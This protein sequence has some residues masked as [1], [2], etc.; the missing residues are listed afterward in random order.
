MAKGKMEYKPIWLLRLLEKE[1]T[2]TRWD[3]SCFIDGDTHAIIKRKGATVAVWRGHSVYVGVR[4]Y[5]V[6]KKAN[7]WTM[8]HVGRA[9]NDV[10]RRFQARLEKQQEIE[11]AKR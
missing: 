5:L 2:A 9:T 4:F 1:Y 11:Y 3:Y 10:K 7:E 8:I 6:D